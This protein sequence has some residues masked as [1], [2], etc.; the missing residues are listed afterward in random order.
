MGRGV[1]TREEYLSLARV[2]RKRP[3]SAMIRGLVWD[4]YEE[5]LGACAEGEGGD[6]LQPRAASGA[7]PGARRTVPCAPYAAIV[8][9]EAQDI[10]E[11]G[12]RFLLELLDGGP[13]GR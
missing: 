4:V 7:R 5:Y 12:V 9:D 10:T 3:M 1:D 11:V 6:G 8:V 2:G 13:K